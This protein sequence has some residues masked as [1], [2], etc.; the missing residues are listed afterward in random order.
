LRGILLRN[1]AKQSLLNEPIA[2]VDEAYFSLFK[3]DYLMIN[4]R[5]EQN[6]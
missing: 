5:A 4:S 3:K 2:F 1:Q 6:V